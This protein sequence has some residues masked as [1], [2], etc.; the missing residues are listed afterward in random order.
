M[1]HTTFANLETRTNGFLT[2][3]ARNDSRTKSSVLLTANYNSDA[4]TD[5]LFDTLGIPCPPNIARAALRRKADYLAGRAITL[6]AM[7]ALDVPPAPVATAPSRAPIWPDGLAGSI[8]HARGRCACLLSQ[9]TNHSYGIDTEAIAQGKSLTAI[10]SETLTASERV[11]IT[12]GPLSPATNA[13]LAFSAKEAL[14][15]ALYP[16]VG[17]HFGFDTAELTAPPTQDQVTLRLMT[18]LT[19]GLTKGQSWTLH[20]HQSGSHVLTWLSVAVP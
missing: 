18:D 9:D 10:L 13:T 20:T 3:M 17:R 15:K 11:T 12:Q 6:A 19:P 2:D 16:Q 14:F 1:D 8:S 7:T 5:T 4:Y